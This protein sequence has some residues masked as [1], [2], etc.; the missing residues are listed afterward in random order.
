MLSIEPSPNGVNLLRNNIKMNN[1]QEKVII[2]NGAASNKTGYAYI[3]IINGREEYSSLGAMFHPSVV[4]QEYVPLKVRTETVDN[5]VS[6]YKIN[7]GFIKIDVEGMEHIVFEGM[8]NTLKYNRPIILSELS[9]H[10]LEKNGTSSI[11]IIRFIKEYNYIVIGPFY[12][13]LIP[14]SRQF[15]DILCIPN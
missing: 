7:P 3:N 14:E 2:F 4:G 5:L 8:I 9:N 12:R 13:N 11:E 6:K 15:G 10:L 1:V